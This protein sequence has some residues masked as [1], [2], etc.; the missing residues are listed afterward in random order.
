MISY[1]LYAKIRHVIEVE[2]LTIPQTADS[3]GI[4][5]RTVRRLSFFVMVLAH[6]RMMYLEFT[7]SQ[8]M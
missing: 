4:D 1:E 3:L 7:T 5:Q 6:S 2:G 8:T